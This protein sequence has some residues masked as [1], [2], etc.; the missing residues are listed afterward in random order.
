MFGKGRHHVKVLCKAP[1]RKLHHSGLMSSAELQVRP[2]ADPVVDA[3]GHRADSPY[4]ELFWLPILGPSATLLMRRL[5]LYLDMRP[6]GLSIDLFDLS[7]QLGLGRP[8]SRHA[9][10]PRA[11]DRC[12]RFTMARRTGPNHLAVRRMLG[13]LPAQRVARLS[14]ALQSIHSH[15]AEYPGRSWSSKASLLSQSG[16]IR[17]ERPGTACA[18]AP[19]ASGPWPKADRRAG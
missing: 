3:K 9:A 2:W 10:L 4:V 19:P 7:A 1:A 16:L 18:L 6:T 12:V 8:E 5:G 17:T 15:F 11:I 13:P 14:P